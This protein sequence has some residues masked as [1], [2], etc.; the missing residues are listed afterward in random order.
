MIRT[1]IYTE[2]PILAHGLLELLSV[3]PS[4]EVLGTP[5][6]LAD[7]RHPLETAAPDILLLDLTSEMTFTELTDLRRSAP[8][9]KI[10]LWANSIPHELAYQVLN[11]GIRGVLRK[12]L[13]AELIIKC[14]HKVHDGELW[15]EKTLTDSFLAADRV[16]LTRRESELVILLSQGM[17]NKEIARA[18]L[19]TEG[20]VKVY[21]SKL[22]QKV[23]VKD[24]FEL[25]LYAL[26]NLGTLA[27][28][29]TPARS[30]QLTS[31]RSLVVDRRQ[32]A[33]P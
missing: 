22:F 9:C 3:D 4:I 1:L 17:K 26:K 23:G 11:L 2:A 15:F 7:L 30:L 16:H 24:R 8:D 6:N 18:L 31:F 28:G 10:V 5:S 21:F 20:T 12:S 25:A 19:I 29:S 27:G 33:L 14:L 13:A 32:F